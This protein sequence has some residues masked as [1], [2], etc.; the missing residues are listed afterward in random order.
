MA[1][2][3]RV[4]V[5]SGSVKYSPSVSIGGG[6]LIHSASGG[7]TACGREEGNGRIR[8]GEQGITVMC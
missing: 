8:E 1:G 4:L 5:E 2:V 3:V 7:G 6:L